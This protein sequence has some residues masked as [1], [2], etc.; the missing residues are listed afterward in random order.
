MCSLAAESPSLDPFFR[1]LAS[2][3]I[4]DI[5]RHASST[6]PSRFLRV[7]VI[8]PPRDSGVVSSLDK[9]DACPKEPDPV[10]VVIVG[11]WGTKAAPASSRLMLILLG[12]TLDFDEP[13]PLVF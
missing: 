2:S 13:W 5:S 6:L 4:R 1:V 10:V 8:F 9:G 12:F 3:A 7:V 11:T